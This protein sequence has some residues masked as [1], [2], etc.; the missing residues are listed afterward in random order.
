VQTNDLN[1]A[2]RMSRALR[3]GSVFVN[4]AAPSNLAATPFGG[5]GLS[6]FGREGG[7][8]GLDEFIHV[9][10]VAMSVR[11]LASAS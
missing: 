3:S 8:A 10:S 9:K 5:L 11:D 7:K 2:Q 6:G 1:V 4:Q